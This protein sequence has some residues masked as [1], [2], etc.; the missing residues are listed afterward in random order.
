MHRRLRGET[1]RRR[2]DTPSSSRD[3]GVSDDVASIDSIEPE[4]AKASSTGAGD[5]SRDVGSSLETGS[6]GTSASP[7]SSDV[8]DVP[9]AGWWPSGGFPGLLDGFRAIPRGAHSRW[10]SP[11]TPLRELDETQVPKHIAIIMDGNSRWAEKRRL[12][13]TIGH[14]RGVNALRQVVRCCGAWGV[15]TLTVFAF[16]H[17][18][19]GRNASEVDELM[20][21]LETAMRDELPLLVEE[22]VRVEVIG[23]LNRVNE[24][25]RDAVDRAMTATK[26][27][28][29]MRLVVALSYGGRQDIV[30]AAKQV[31]REVAA[32]KLSVDDVNEHTF[33]SYL[34]TYDKTL[35]SSDIH[36]AQAP[37]LLIRTS[38]QRLSN[39][40]LWELAYTE[41]YFANMMWPEFGEA[42]LRRALHA[43]AKRDRRYG[44]RS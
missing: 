16:S 31:A 25:L 17:E 1:I 18:N 3:R 32:G 21:L 28:D 26:D 34:S 38:E 39:F 40:L 2:A 24:G 4:L 5:V 36:F 22:G 15:R 27:N 33:S 43:Y 9:D 7:S 37:D 42:E 35:A 19:W 12:P 11:P 29:K 8:E 30:E 10:N 41:L 44:G 23:D 13:R 20:A 6:R 14:E